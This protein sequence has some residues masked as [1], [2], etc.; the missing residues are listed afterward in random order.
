MKRLFLPACAAWLI[1]CAGAPTAPSAPGGPIVEVRESFTCP[2]PASRGLTTIARDGKAERVVFDGL[3]FEL[4]KTKST[5]EQ[6]TLS[7]SD[8]AELFRLVADS[9]WRVLPED[10]VES[11]PAC[12]DCCSG[13]LLIKTNEGGKSLRYM[14]EKKAAKLDSLIKNIDAILARGS[15]ARVVYPWEKQR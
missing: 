12:A 15:W 10:P 9:D 13:A 8:T 7:P 14:G 6:M 3:E 2:S 11:G 4:G 1:S 5:R